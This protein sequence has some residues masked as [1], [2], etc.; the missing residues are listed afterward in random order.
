MFWL[1]AYLA[2]RDFYKRDS[3]VHFMAEH[4]DFTEI[5]KLYQGVK[6]VYKDNKPF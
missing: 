3:I 5:S 4:F 2:I 6:Q 1:G